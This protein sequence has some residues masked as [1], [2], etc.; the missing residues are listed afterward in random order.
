[1]SGGRSADQRS[2][3]G[4]VFAVLEAFEG[5]PGPIRLSE[6]AR[7][8]DLPVSTAHRLVN[9]LVGWDALERTADNR[10]RLGHRV[11]RLGATTSW[12][13][14]LRR[15]CARFTHRLAGELGHAVAVSALHGDRLICLDTVAGQHPT[16]ELARAGDEL[17][18]FATSAGKLLLASVNRERFAGLTAGGIPRL[19]RRSLTS[20]GVLTRQLEFARRNGYALAFGESAVGQA[21]VS[22][23]IAGAAPLALTVLTP[24]HHPDPSRLVSPLRGAAD[25]I[26]RA[27]A[28]SA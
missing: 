17:P 19:T 27:L 7:R 26:G 10:Y 20:L 18:L 21:S 22:V 13:R 11:W 12:E 8:A 2:G 28:L 25:T 4:R 15:T 3:A 9:E 6:L 23:P 24:I 5:T 1:M 14:Q 16:V